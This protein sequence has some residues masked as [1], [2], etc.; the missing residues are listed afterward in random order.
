[1]AL[2]RSVRVFGKVYTVLRER[3]ADGSLGEC[4]FEATA[5]RVAPDA[6]PVLQADTFL[7]EVLHAILHEMQVCLPYK[8]EEKAVNAIATGLTGVLQDNPE[9]CKYL[10]SNHNKE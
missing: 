4:E 2:P 5:I 7:H 8:T 3:P 9:V 6:A 1:M 10:T